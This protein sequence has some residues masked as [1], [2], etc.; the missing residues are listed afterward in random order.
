MVVRLKECLIKRGFGQIGGYG[1]ARPLKTGLDYFPFDV[2]FFEDRKIKR[3][4]AKFGC[5]GLA[6]YLCILCL[7]YNDKGYYIEWDEYLIADIS[8]DL[9]LPEEKVGRIM[10]ICLSMGLLRA[11]ELQ[12]CERVLSSETIQRRFQDIKVSSKRD[13]IVK[14]EC[15]FLKE[16]ETRAFIKFEEDNADSF[17]G[18]NEDK[19][20]INTQRKGKE[21][22]V[23]ESKGKESEYACAPT[24]TKNTYGKYKNVFLTDAELDDLKNQFSGDYRERIERLS[25]YKEYT[26]KVYK[27]DLATIEHWARHDKKNER[28]SPKATANFE[29]RVYDA[30]TLEEAFARKR[31]GDFGA[32]PHTPQAF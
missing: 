29:Q 20:R 28:A 24:H 21:S 15:W 27:N 16:A 3:L 32:L 26:G 5:D 4:R 6:V 2:G 7:I 25:E 22:K 18:K 14:K 30:K 19:S 13:V 9:N 10:D 8:V 11:K 17:Y 12:N 31:E 23:K 1:M